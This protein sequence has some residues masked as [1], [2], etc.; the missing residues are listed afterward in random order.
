MA[1]LRAIPKPKCAECSRPATVE[2]VN[3]YNAT[4]GYYCA[5]HGK[6]AEGRMTA[7]EIAAGMVVEQSR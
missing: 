6:R 1:H 7:R 5:A 2:L 3:R 4:C